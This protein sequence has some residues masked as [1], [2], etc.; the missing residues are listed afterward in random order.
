MKDSRSLPYNLPPSYTSFQLQVEAEGSGEG[1]HI[2][3]KFLKEDMSPGPT[4]ESGKKKVEKPQF[5]GLGK[6]G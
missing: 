6:G 1:A 4:K 3:G 5:A 2:E